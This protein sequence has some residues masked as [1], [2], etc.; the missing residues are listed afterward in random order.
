MLFT[1]E[2]HYLRASKLGDGCNGQGIYVP[3]F[4]V[5]LW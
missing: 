2:I 4:S 3:I 1:T 5:P